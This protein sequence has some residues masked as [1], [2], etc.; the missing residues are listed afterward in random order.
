ME[1]SKKK[2]ILQI[3]YFR[4]PIKNMIIAYDRFWPQKLF[5]LCFVAIYKNA[6]MLTM[7][8]DQLDLYKRE[9]GLIKK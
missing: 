7:N 3:Y 8:T 6:K 5:E 9:I 4:V 1:K 2:K